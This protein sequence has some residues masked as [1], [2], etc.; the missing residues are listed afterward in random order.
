VGVQ[1]RFWPDPQPLVTRLGQRFFR[2]IPQHAGVYK[3][4]DA[5]ERIVYVGK[6]KNLRQRLRSYRVADPERLPRR[7]MRLLHEVVRIEF[8]FCASESAALE[9]EAKLIRELKPKFNRAGVWQGK[10]QFFCWRFEKEAIEFDVQET[11]RAGWERFGPLGS[12]TMQLRASLIR[13]LWLRTNR[14]LTILQR[15]TGTKKET[16]HIGFDQKPLATFLVFPKPLPK[17]DGADVIGINYDLLEETG[18]RVPLE[19]YKPPKIIKKPKVLPTKKEF[20][21]DILRIATVHT[22]LVISAENISDAEAEAL[23]SVKQKKFE[24]KDIQDEIKSIVEIK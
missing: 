4:R 21:V 17:S 10:R 7:R 9:H 23:K 5:S 13:L 1:Q 16:G 20:R 18:K 6:A 11:P 2:E 19:E 8:T 14:V 3:M 22:E 24:P 15:P 12:Y